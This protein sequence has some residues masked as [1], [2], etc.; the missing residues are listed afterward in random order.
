[1]INLEKLI[2]TLLL[3]LAVGNITAYQPKDK[4]IDIPLTANSVGNVSTNLITNT[5]HLLESPDKDWECIKVKRTLYLGRKTDCLHH[6][7]Y[8]LKQNPEF[9]SLD[10]YHLKV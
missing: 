8:I 5:F 2:I 4:D 7:L 1:M 3:S 9:D 6:T 10:L